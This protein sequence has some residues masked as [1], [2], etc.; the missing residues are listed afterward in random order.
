MITTQ[1]QMLRVVFCNWCDRCNNILWFKKLSESSYIDMLSEQRYCCDLILRK[2]KTKSLGR[3]SI[4]F[5]PFEIFA[6]SFL[7]F[8]SVF[9]RIS[10]CIILD[11]RNFCTIHRLYMTVHVSQITDNTTVCL[12][13]CPE[14]QRNDQEFPLLTLC[15]RNPHQETATRTY[16]VF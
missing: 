4:F 14:R 12:M 11:M 6:T 9:N 13:T 3:N 2:V 8:L 15:E 1:W 10:S 7:F 5:L 16:V